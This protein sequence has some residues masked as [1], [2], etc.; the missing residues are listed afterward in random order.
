LSNVV[1]I[2]AGPIDSMALKADGTV[3]QW[4]Y[5]YYNQTNVPLGLSN[6]IAI[7]EGHYH[8][9]VLA[10]MVP[11]ANSQVAAGSANHDL[12]VALSASDVNGETLSLRIV[13]LPAAGT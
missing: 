10:N 13:S 3:T 6:V 7:A 1:A 8:S 2:T 12:A 11:K 5:N 9:L 4:G